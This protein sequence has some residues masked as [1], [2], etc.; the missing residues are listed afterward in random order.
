MLKCSPSS[1]RYV[2]HIH[3]KDLKWTVNPKA[4]KFQYQDPSGK[5]IMLSSYLVMI[6]DE[7]FKKYVE[8]YAKGQ[9]LNTSNLND[10]LI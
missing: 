9:V 1:V 10:L 4:L 5:L 2:Q 6:Q 7:N 8:I 3:A